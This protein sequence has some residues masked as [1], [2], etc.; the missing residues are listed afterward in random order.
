MKI[1]FRN[2]AFRELRTAP[3]VR[4]DLEQRAERV[5]AAAGDGVE[6]LPVQEPRNRAHVVVATVT[7]DAARQNAE[8]NTLLRA[9]D[10]GR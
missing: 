10:A 5:A 1:R 3:G 8:Q 7:P 6:V 2:A 4:A 9:L